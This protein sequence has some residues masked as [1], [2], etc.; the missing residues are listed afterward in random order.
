VGHAISWWWQLSHSSLLGLLGVLLS[1]DASAAVV[2]VNASSSEGSVD[3]LLLV[4]GGDLGVL[5]GLSLLLNWHGDTLDLVLGGG[6]GKLL[7]GGVWEPALLW[8]GVAL[9]EHDQVVL[10]GVESSNVLLE[11]VLVSGGSSVIYSN[12]NLSGTSLGEASSLQLLKSKAAAETHLTGVPAG[13][14][15]DNWAERVDWSWED[16]SS[17]GLSNSVSLGLLGCLIEVGFD[18]NSLPVLAEMH[19]DNHVV[20]LDHC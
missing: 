6:A 15:G 5:D 12:S 10:I 17:L 20:M 4:L 19:V 9:G 8:L 1:L 7:L 3:H 18:A 16:A 2:S 13:G 14:L 11:V